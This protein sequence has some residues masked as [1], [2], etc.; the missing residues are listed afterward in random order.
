MAMIMTLSF[1]NGFQDEIS[2]K[3][4]SFWGHIHVKH[5]E[6]SKSLVAE[7]IPI[8]KNDTILHIIEQ[9]PGLKRISTFATKSAV[10]ENKKIIEGIL[11]KG[12]DKNYDSGRLQS[13]ISAGKLI[14]FN[15]SNYSRDILVSQTIAK[16]L[17]IQLLDTVLIH[18]ITGKEGEASSYRK[19]VVSGIYKTGIEEYDKLFAITDIRLLQKINNWNSSQ[20]GGYEISINDYTRIDEFN[21][22]LFDK[23]P[24]EWVSRTTKEIYP[25]IFDWLNIQDINRNIVF[26]VMS[27]V[28]IINLISCLLVLVL[29]RTKMVGILKAIGTT[30]WDIQKIFLY[31]ALIITITGIS[32]GLIAGLGLSYL[33]QFTHFIRLDESSYYISYAPIKII[34]WQITLVCGCTGII[35]FLSLII[36]STIIRNLSPVN[37]IKFR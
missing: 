27:V 31:H 30:E 13:F 32:L 36:P 11:L 12:I 9:Q 37:A 19:L 22:Q 14:N 1:V 26:I 16:T 2:K 20:I 3:V 4:F 23:L 35:C 10:M 24:N 21:N 29:E 5:L 15:N 8:K 7:E 6:A 28:A 33:Q 25:N 34:G 17:K 18:F